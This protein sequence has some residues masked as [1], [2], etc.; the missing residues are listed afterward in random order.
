MPTLC[1]FRR[2]LARAE[3]L[4]SLFLLAFSSFVV[5][6]RFPLN[7]QLSP[8]FFFCFCFTIY[9]FPRQPTIHLFN[10]LLDVTP[11]E[12]FVALA[13]ENHLLLVNLLY[14]LWHVKFRSSGLKA[15]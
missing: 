11:I 1:I 3:R 12:V 10:L 6:F 7:L 13:A 5:S 15:G 9:T 8:V 2:S 4:L 14:P